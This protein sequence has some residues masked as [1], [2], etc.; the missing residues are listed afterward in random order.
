MTDLRICAFLAT[1][2][3]A[4]ACSDPSPGGDGAASRGT[5]GAVTAATLGAQVVL[6]TSDYLKLPEY[7]NA[8][9]DLGARLVM[10]CRACHSFET[11]GPS[12]SGPNL[13]GVFGR[14]AGGVDGYPYSPALAEADFI[15]TPQALDAWLAQPWAFLPGNRMSYPGL[16]GASERAAVIAELLR[17]TIAGEDSRNR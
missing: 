13:F 16:S 2:A 1:V 3:L 6:P 11:G 12:I 7:E 9:R 5:S 8:D 17:V 4:S 14:P 10:Q 15:W